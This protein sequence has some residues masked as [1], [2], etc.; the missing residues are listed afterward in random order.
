M[1]TS[2]VFCLRKCHNESME[3]GDILRNDTNRDII[4]VELKTEAKFVKSDK[5]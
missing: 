2:E 4:F 1:T 3:I 5:E